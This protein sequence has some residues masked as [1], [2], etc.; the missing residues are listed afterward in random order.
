M[1]FELGEEHIALRRLVRDFAEKEVAPIAAEVDASGQFPEGVVTKLGE[2]G[3]L[4]LPFPEEYG[5]G[6]ADELSY[7]ILLEELARVDCGLGL[8]VEAHISLGGSPL[9]RWGTPEQK[10]RWLIPLAQGR[11]MGSIGLTE[12]EAGSDLGGI[13]TTA[14]L[15]GDEWVINGNKC[16]IT[17]AGAG[18]HGLV[19]V[20]TVTGQ[21]E[22]GRKE[23]SIIIVPRGTPGY[24]VSEPRQKLGL[25]SSDTRDLS[26]TDCRVP[27]ENLLGERGAGYRQALA[28]LDE[29]RFGIAALG[30]GLSQAC[31]ELSL[32][33]ARER[34]Q[35]GK[36]LFDFQV[37]QF[38]LADIAINVELARLITYKAA[39]LCQEGK[40]YT[41]EAAMAKVF[42]SEVAV[43]AA[44]EGVQIHGGYGYMSECPLSR[45]YR[46]AK[47]LT[48][49]E[50]TSEVQR[51]VIA[52]HLP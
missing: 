49:G 8:S 14:A 28:V 40:P 9:N 11:M 20:L 1:N 32:Q 51:M 27:R 31:L 46:D 33:Y 12:P 10:R 44:E 21:R 5:G 7:A 35:F 6:G 43:R 34:K 37:I 26:F 25:H 52:R 16:F 23:Y 19:N 47:L 48:I 45:F 41:K 2:L 39:V 24:E 3:L 29:G 4:G 36:P 22:D 42:A 15:D 50:G 30:V 13:S 17:N 38:K 18:S